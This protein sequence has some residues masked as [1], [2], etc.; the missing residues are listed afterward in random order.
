M[1]ELKPCPFCGGEPEDFP[2]GDGSGLM[3]QCAHERCVNPHVSYIPASSAI[4]AWNTRADIAQ[5]RIAEL[6]EALALAD[7]TL[8]GANM[9]RAAVERKV[10]AALKG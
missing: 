9:D 7:A 8:S 6:E 5:A 3:I 10:R 2:S 1:T 4:A